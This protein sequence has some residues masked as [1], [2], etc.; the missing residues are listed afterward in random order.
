MKDIHIRSF[1]YRGD[2]IIHDGTFH[3][4]LQN[5]QSL[6]EA[7]RLDNDEIADFLLL[8]FLLV[9]S[10]IDKLCLVPISLLDL[11]LVENLSNL[12]LAD[13]SNLK[14]SSDIWLKL[15]GYS[16]L[17]FSNIKRINELRFRDFLQQAVIHSLLINDLT[18]KPSIHFCLIKIIFFSFPCKITKIF[19]SHFIT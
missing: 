1:S 13:I 9:N 11:I 16:L 7:A 19:R 4:F 18:I 8:A 5:G 2:D 3:A 10:D 15:F 12:R 17:S 14:F 6:F